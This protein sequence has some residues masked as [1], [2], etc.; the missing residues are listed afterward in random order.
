[1][2][3]SKVAKVENLTKYLIQIDEIILNRPRRLK[4]IICTKIKKII[5]KYVW[6]LKIALQC[7][8]KWVLLPFILQKK[9]YF[10]PNYYKQILWCALKNKEV[11]SQA[12][13]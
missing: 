6:V 13:N 7:L 4:F 11:F 8:C 5:K 2:I 10:T 1:M 12:P 9:I 3:Y